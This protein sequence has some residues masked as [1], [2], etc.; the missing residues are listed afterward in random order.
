M[1]THLSRGIA[2]MPQDDPTEESIFAL[3]LEKPS[4]AERAA[5]VE[6]ACVGRPTLLERV[7]RLL[8]SHEEAGSFLQQPAASATESFGQGQ[9]S[10]TPGSRIGPYKLLQQIG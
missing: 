3:A 7:E 8:R 4:T 6:A 9:L 1:E 5:F 10:E 2:V